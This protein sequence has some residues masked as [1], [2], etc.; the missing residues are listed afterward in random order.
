[1]ALE[2]REFLAACAAGAVAVTLNWPEATEAETGDPLLDRFRTPGADARPHTW[3]HWMNGNATADGITRDLEAMARVGVG[4]AHMFDVGC[5]IPQGPAKTLNAEWVRLIRHAADE[6]GRLGLA[7]IMHD[8]PGWSSSGGPWITP[9]RAMQQLVWS[10]AA[11]DG[12][13]PV[14]RVLPKPFTRLDHYRD[15]MVVAYPA[16]PGD[17]VRGAWPDRSRDAQW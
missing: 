15:A 6:C 1:M 3:W 14:D 13:K 10:E 11:L 16:L 5:G 9:D 12:G 8:C 17:R 7:F 2:R 4:G